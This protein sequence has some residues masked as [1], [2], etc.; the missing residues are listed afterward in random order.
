MLDEMKPMD[1]EHDLGQVCRFLGYPRDVIPDERTCKQVAKAIHQVA[2]QAEPRKTYREFLREEVTHLLKGEDIRQHVENCGQVLLLAVTLGS[3]MD[4]LLRK[5]AV[6]GMDEAVILEAAANALIEQVAAQTEGE[7]RQHY[8][9][10][11]LFI[12][13]RYSPGY[14]DL[15]LE[16][17]PDLLQLLEAGKTI[18]LYASKEHLLTP[19]K[20]ITAICG[21]A[22][23]PVEGHLAGCQTCAL[24]GTCQYQQYKKE[25]RHCGT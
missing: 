14:G 23:T 16:T 20:S 18:G 25:G 5:T 15:P 4:E 13:P 8:G 10:K 2:Q 6:T 17:Q 19:R 9:E 21:I 7:L 11:G 12:T 22:K 3:Q 1:H 24:Q